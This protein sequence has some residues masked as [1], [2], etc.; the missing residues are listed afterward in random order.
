M[1]GKLGRFDITKTLGSGA[2]CK[3]KLGTDSNTGR[4]VAVKI[5]KNMDESMK[6][7][8]ENEITT[9]KKF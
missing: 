1:P 8:L 5:F 3:V 7:L 2:S 4:N 6:N 9:M